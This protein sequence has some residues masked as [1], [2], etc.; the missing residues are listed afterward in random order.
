MD[1]AVGS[2]VES[3]ETGA[4]EVLS[5]RNES[6]RQIDEVMVHPA[7]KLGPGRLGS[8]IRG[9]TVVLVGKPEARASGVSCAT[10][11]RALEEPIAMSYGKNR[12]S[13]IVFCVLLLLG[14][15]PV[16]AVFIDVQ[17]IGGVD[18]A[19]FRTWA[20]GEGS[21]LPNQEVERAA[22][23]TLEQ[24]M[25]AKG[26]T[27][28]ENEADCL[29]TIHAQADEWF[30]G[31]LFKIE[32]VDGK[33]GKTVW[34]GKAEGAINVQNTSKRQKLAQRTVKK[35]FKKFPPRRTE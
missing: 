19:G 2:V 10:E 23:V 16:A 33:T 9:A 22:R 20:F 4:Q 12:A 24:Q 14:T 27:R 31:G 32:A 15:I 5:L 21:P 26:Y 25:A 3:S 34:R 6:N 29:I 13:L 28:V 35:M 30:D 7:T 17:F 1:A 18:I 8:L 11:G